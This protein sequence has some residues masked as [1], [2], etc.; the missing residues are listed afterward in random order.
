MAF[1]Y[2]NEA[3]QTAGKGHFT[4]VY[5]DST[6]GKDFKLKESRFALDIKKKFFSL[7]VVRNWSK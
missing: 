4:G 7:R 2:Q 5:H 6:K 1:H 3:Y